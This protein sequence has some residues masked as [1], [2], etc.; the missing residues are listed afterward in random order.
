MRSIAWM[1]IAGSFGCN[2]VWVCSDAEQ[3]AGIDCCTTDARC[4]SVYGDEFPVCVAPGRHS[5]VCSECARDAQCQRDQVC[6]IKESGLG[7]CVDD[8]ER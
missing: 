2:A 7:V 5:G 8:Q 1:L 3:R 4:E 6:L